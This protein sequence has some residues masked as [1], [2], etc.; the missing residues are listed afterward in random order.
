MPVYVMFVTDGGTQDEALSERMIREAASEPIF[1]CFMA[2]GRAPD[3][4]PRGWF[5]LPSGF[6]FLA[7][8]DTMQDRVVDNAHFFAV[9]DPSAPGDEELFELMMEE[10]PE[11]QTAAHNAGLFQA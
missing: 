7:R 10:F 3:S 4:K 5:S 11:W 1:W 6:E 2:I 9:E 8:L